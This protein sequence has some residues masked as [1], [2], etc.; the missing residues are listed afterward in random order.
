MDEATSA[1]IKNHRRWKRACLAV[2]LVWLLNLALTPTALK[3]M[4]IA[5]GSVNIMDHGYGLTLIFGYLGAIA[6]MALGRAAGIM[7]MAVG[8]GLAAIINAVFIFAAIFFFVERSK[9]AKLE[10]KK[11]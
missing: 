1:K 11:D 2:I 8:S 10:A 9:I 3:R 7:V 6:T 5:P 4:G